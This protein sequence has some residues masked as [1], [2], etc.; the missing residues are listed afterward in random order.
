MRVEEDRSDDEDNKTNSDSGSNNE[1]NSYHESEAVFDDNSSHHSDT[2]SDVSNK[3]LPGL[4]STLSTALR[5]RDTIM[6]DQGQNMKRL[7]AQPETK[8]K[9][10]LN[11][12]DAQ[13]S[14]KVT[15]FWSL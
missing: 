3:K 13:T 15:G 2:S 7:S 10:K 9:A 11:K 6:G 1:S 5:N 8:K 14:E 12:R 4:Q